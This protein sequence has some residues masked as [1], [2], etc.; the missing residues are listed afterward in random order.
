[1]SPDGG[2]QPAGHFR[3]LAVASGKWVQRFED[4]AETLLASVA[5]QVIG[6]DA[7]RISFFQGASLKYSRN[8]QV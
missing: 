7:L 3:R 2:F 1:M 5:A 8:L 6:E 4:A